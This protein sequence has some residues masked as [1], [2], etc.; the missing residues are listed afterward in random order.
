MKVDSIMF[1]NM[2]SEWKH[3][4]WVGLPIIGVYTSDLTE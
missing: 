1:C 3:H 4:L 2:I